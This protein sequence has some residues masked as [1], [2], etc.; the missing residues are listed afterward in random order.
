MVERL[1]L[2]ETCHMPER[3]LVIVTQNVPFIGFCEACNVPFLSFKP[4]AKDAT[5]IV[6]AQFDSHICTGVKNN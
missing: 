2:W 6:Q 4:D 5:Q 3:N 1:M